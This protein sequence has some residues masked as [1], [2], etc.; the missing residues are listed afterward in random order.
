MSRIAYVGRR[1]FPHRSAAVHI[2]D[3]AHRFAD[4]VYEMLAV[5]GSCR[6]DEELPVVRIDGNPIWGV[7]PGPLSRR[8][9]NG[10][11]RTA[12]A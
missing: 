11:H 5:V 7:I 8:L 10:Y 2:E 6:V 12:A 3:R 9:G 4:A 1:S